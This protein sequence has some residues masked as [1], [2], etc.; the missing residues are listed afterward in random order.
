MKK[1]FP[2]ILVILIT[3]CM[4]LNEAGAIPAFARRYKM[5]CTTCHAPFPKLK[6][7]GDDF[8]GAGFILKEEEK[9]RDYI[10]AGDDLLWLNRHF[11]VG[12]RFDAYMMYDEKR[13]VD[14]DLQVPWGLKIMSGGTLYKNIGYYF[15]F[16]L[17]ERGEVAGI[18]DAYVHFDDI[19]KLPI[20]VMVGQFQTSDPLMKR[21]LRLTFEDYMIY[22]QHVGLST[23]NLAYDRGVMLVL[24]LARTGTD[25]IGMAV[26]GN[27]KPE[28]DENQKFDSD[29]YKNFGLRIAQSIGDFASIGGFYY[30]GKERGAGGD[31]FNEL[32]YWG[33][34]LNI[35]LGPLEF[36]VQY[37]ERRDSNPFFASM[38][39]IKTKGIVAEAIFAPQ[40]DRSRVYFT[41]LYNQIDSGLDDLPDDV[42][43]AAEVERINYKTATLSVSY[44]VARNLRLVAEYTRDLRRDANRFAMGFV[45]GF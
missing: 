4:G 44:L 3:F 13:D 31:P 21:E 27:G 45:S 23:T 5:S 14:K 26:N 9:P 38:G 20:D 19:F 25:I 7:Y 30:W 40:G 17:S 43:L 22:K 12:V 11:P 2:A 35:G 36:T 18:E 34:D 6:P 15:Y 42:L 29:K 1:T 32:T 41:A 10:A 37:L 39:A 33:P 24:G 28:A 8:A 16:Y